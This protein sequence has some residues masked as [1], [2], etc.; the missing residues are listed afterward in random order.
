MASVL[1][2]TPSASQGVREIRPDFATLR[3]S[4]YDRLD[5]GGHAYLD[6]TGAALYARSQIEAHHARL[7]TGVLGNPHSENPAARES[8]KRMEAARARALAFF[9]ADPAEYDLV[10]TPNASA[11]LKLVGESFP[12]ERGSS[13]VLTAD[14]HNSVN[15][16]REFAARAGARVRYVPLDA[17]LRPAAP[18]PWLEGARSGR[19]HLF[20]YPAQSNYS[21]A[22]HPLEWVELA[23]DAGYHV[24]L[25]TAAYAPTRA[26]DLSVLRPDFACV[27]FYKMF[28]FPTGVGAL[29]ARRDA[30][31]LL[32]RPWFAGGTIEWVATYERAHALRP[33]S[34]AF[35]DGTPPFLAFDAV[36]D[37]LDLLES[38]G[39][40][41]VDAHVRAMTA[42]MLRGLG[43]LRHSGGRPLV[44]VYGPSDLERR[45]GTVAF[46]V[47]DGAGCVIPFEQVVALAADRRVSLRGGCFCNPGCEETALGFAP[48][49]TRECRRALRGRYSFPSFSACRGGP[50][51]AVRASVGIPTIESDVDRLLDALE[52]CS[53]ERAAG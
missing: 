9:R 13:F 40:E 11:A 48:Q 34:G 16:I 32:R 37:G 31:A 36:C 39:M 17:T 3:H 24:L 51:G 1:T 44:T 42:R 19:P 25:D 14:N 8:T 27:S 41:R 10:F 47:L 7:L 29:I 50:A 4:E 33:G 30:L 52:G 20:A 35:E 38:I 53:R 21:G 18:G 2:K 46:N 6:Y 43:A 12:F 22:R 45:G 23:H 49:Q 26:L 5:A 28:G 15:G